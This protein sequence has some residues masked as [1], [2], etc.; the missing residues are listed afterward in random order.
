MLVSREELEKLNL[1]PL[2]EERNEK[3]RE[4]FGDSE[5]FVCLCLEAC[6]QVYP[7]GSCLVCLPSNIFTNDVLRKIESLATED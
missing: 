6:G 7:S 5:R 1:A 2:E 3:I 4:L